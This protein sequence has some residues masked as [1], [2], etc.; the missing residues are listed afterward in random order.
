MASS[1]SPLVLQFSGSFTEQNGMEFRSL[2]VR[3]GADESSETVLR[4]ACEVARRHD[5]SVTGLFVIDVSAIAGFGAADV[6]PE[7]FERQRERLQEEAVQAERIFSAACANS[8]VE[9]E[10]RTVEGTTQW[11]VD[12]HARHCDLLCLGAARGGGRFLLDE[13]LIFSTGRPV[14]VVPPEYA[15]AGIGDSVALAWNASRESARA[16]GDAMGILRKATSV[17]VV[18]VADSSMSD[19]ESDMI[20]IDVGRF[21]ARHGIHVEPYAVHP[22]HVPVG[23]ALHDWVHENGVDLLVMG[24]YG[25]SRLLEM[26]TGGVTHWMLRH[27]TIPVLM[28]H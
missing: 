21:F 5:A 28:S 8:D 26:I 25:H 24:A 4:A 11:V 15:G 3:V 10:W 23:Q 14:L 27:A 1:R 6:P 22:G 7:I 16:Q 9:A 13:D 20:G 2:L 17:S 19:R 12:L 18:T